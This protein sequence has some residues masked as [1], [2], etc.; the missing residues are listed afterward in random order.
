MCNLCFKPPSSAECESVPLTC[1][2]F[3]AYHA[4]YSPLLADAKDVVPSLSGSIE[5]PPDELL[6]ELSDW[7]CALP[8]SYDAELREFV[9]KSST[10]RILQTMEAPSELSAELP[11]GTRAMASFRRTTY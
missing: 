10:R 3:I 2:R 5:V 11:Q 7:D 4:Y 9:R 1:S 8:A 6:A